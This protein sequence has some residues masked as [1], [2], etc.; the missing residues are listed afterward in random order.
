LPE[1]ASDVAEVEARQPEKQKR[2]RER[3]EHDG[4][5]SCEDAQSSHD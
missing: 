3:E 4:G 1:T 2:S 5:P